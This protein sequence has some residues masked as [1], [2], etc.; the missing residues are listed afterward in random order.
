VIVGVIRRKPVLTHASIICEG[1]LA[2]VNSVNNGVTAKICKLNYKILTTVYVNTSGRRLS[3]GVAV[4]S[5][6]HVSGTPSCNCSI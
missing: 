4:C 5:C 6:L 3:N 1:M 2:S